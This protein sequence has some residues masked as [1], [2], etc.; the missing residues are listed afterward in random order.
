[1]TTIADQL[2]DKMVEALKPQLTRLSYITLTN[3]IA[4]ATERTRAW[5]DAQVP[6][7]E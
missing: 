2:L 3:A 1:M 4:E 5:L 6:E 7:D